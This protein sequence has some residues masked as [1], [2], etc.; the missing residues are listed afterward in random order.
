ML[1][2]LEATLQQDEP[3][4]LI[5]RN[6]GWPTVAAWLEAHRYLLWSY[7]PA[8]NRLTRLSG[9]PT[10]TNVVTITAAW[11]ARH[12]QMSHL[13]AESAHRHWQKRSTGPEAGVNCGDASRQKPQ[14]NGSRSVAT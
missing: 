12:P 2:G 10:T 11:L 4:L 6:S 1:Q 8:R 3:L 13:I 14:A 7:D 9:E 5:E